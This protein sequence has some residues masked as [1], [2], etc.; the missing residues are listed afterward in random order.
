[1]VDIARED[2]EFGC[3]ILLKETSAEYDNEK[4]LRLERMSAVEISKR[5]ERGA[6]YLGYR[7]LYIKCQRGENISRGEEYRLKALK[8]ELTKEEM[9][10][11]KYKV[12][13]EEV[14]TATKTYA[15][16]ASN[17]EKEARIEA[18]IQFRTENRKEF[19]CDTC[20]R[21]GHQTDECI[22]KICY[23]CGEPGGASHSIGRCPNDKR[24]DK[25]FRNDQE[26]ERKYA[27]KFDTGKM[28]NTDASWKP[29]V[30]LWHDPIEIPGQKITKPTGEELNEMVRSYNGKPEWIIMMD[31]G[32]RKTICMMKNEEY[33]EKMGN[34]QGEVNINERFVLK[35][36]AVLGRK[37]TQVQ[38]LGL[39]LRVSNESIRGY[40]SNFGRVESKVNYMTTKVDGEEIPNGVREYY[41]TLDK[42][43]ERTHIIKGRKIIFTY[44]NQGE[45]C[46]DCF[47]MNCL[48]KITCDSR[49]VLDD[50]R[51]TVINRMKESGATETMIIPFNDFSDGDEEEMD[52][53][54]KSRDKV[55]LGQPKT[56]A[57]L[58]SE[59]LSLVG[60]T[61]GSIEA[62]KEVA[63]VLINR[64]LKKDLGDEADKF[65]YQT[66]RQGSFWST[67]ILG[68]VD[69][70]KQLGGY[71]EELQKD[72]P[73]L[74]MR[75]KY[76]REAVKENKKP[77]SRI[78]LAIHDIQEELLIGNNN[79][80]K[81]VEM[82]LEAEN[83]KLTE[84][85][86]KLCDSI[87]VK[88][89]ELE[90]EKITMVM[91]ELKENC[92]E[93]V[94]ANEEEPRAQLLQPEYWQSKE[95]K[96]KEKMSKA[97]KNINAR[98]MVAEKIKKIEEM[99]EEK[100]VQ[101]NNYTKRISELERT[102]DESLNLDE[103][104]RLTWVKDFTQERRD[105]LANILG[106]SVAQ[107][108]ENDK[109]SPWHQSTP[110][111]T[112]DK[113]LHKD[114]MNSSLSDSP[115]NKQFKD[116]LDNNPEASDL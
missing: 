45:E 1:M 13:T 96:V 19:K 5:R 100:K 112:R 108:D 113:R 109:P 110:T 116:A 82:E 47:R 68:M 12:E 55:Q 114:V 51:Q 78:E 61:V 107:L 58:E 22:N 24:G 62:E 35:Y 105:K 80:K 97:L 95:K 26:E 64:L 115:D 77:L 69:D 25:T 49:I 90:S 14:L 44:K 99:R 65:K 9:D 8:R 53:E 67:D 59:K 76:A 71:L 83:R 30:I 86:K 43:L 50:W 81:E 75:W 63:E 23:Y 111:V 72:T 18:Q 87:E 101:M 48:N 36:S 91:H 56:D 21:K 70:L 98:G 92:P 74:S 79:K 11:I 60:V 27:R 7:E 29:M 34:E 46:R 94:N 103:R 85:N 66:K 84:L 16:A 17:R 4:E 42:P 89:K 102:R 28:K 39:D 31:V 6:K 38:V 10:H 104:Y 32:F 41:V 93:Y 54:M 40:L 88:E 20:G 37:E 52:I 15:N 3:Y 33:A 2:V 106:N 57:E 73:S